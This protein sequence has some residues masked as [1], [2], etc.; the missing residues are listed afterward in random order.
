MGAA[1]GEVVILHQCP[2]LVMLLKEFH[3]SCSKPCDDDP[4][5]EPRDPERRKQE[6][7]AAIVQFRRRCRDREDL[8]H[9]EHR[10]IVLEHRIMMTELVDR[11]PMLDCERH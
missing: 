1:L 4:D 2:V 9:E 5:D 3:H 10:A 8:A 11:V 7:E 6:N